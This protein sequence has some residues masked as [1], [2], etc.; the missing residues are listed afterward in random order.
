MAEL[1]NIDYAENLFQAID[2][3]IAE[4]IR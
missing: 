4:R 1:N 2:T 3:I